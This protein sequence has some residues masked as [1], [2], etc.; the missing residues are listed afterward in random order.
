[1]S[2]DGAMNVWT[3]A[4]APQLDRDAANDDGDD[5]G[6]VSAAEALLR[7]IADRLRRAG[8]D[9][10]DVVVE[11]PGAAVQMTH[12]D[13]ML[14]LLLVPKGDDWRLAVLDADE[15]EDP[16]PSE[17]LA[18][19]LTRIDRILRTTVGIRRIRFRAQPQSGAYRVRDV[20]PSSESAGR[21]SRRAG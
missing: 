9:V 20:A 21:S 15:D 4:A 8:L 19:L 5:D 18:E 1:M 11:E 13:D 14:R 6:E 7:R 3:L 12:G 2:A 17:A 16:A 10:D